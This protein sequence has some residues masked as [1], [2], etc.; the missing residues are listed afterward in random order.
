MNANLPSI[1]GIRQASLIVLCDFDGTIVDVDTC[2][3]ILDRFSEEDWKKLDVQYKKGEISLEKCLQSQF[4][5]LRMH[6]KNQIIHTVM[7][8]TRLRR[9][10]KKLVE[11][12]RTESIPL[13]II[14]AGLDFII[15]HFMKIN[16]WSN[17]IQIYSPRSE[18]T[19][20]GVSFTF[21]KLL[22]KTS[23]NFKDD[24]A[25]N[26]KE[27]N[28][29]VVY[30]GDGTSD[31]EAAKFADY[32]FAIE[33]SSLAQLLK[34]NHIPF[35]EVKT[36]LEVLEVVVKANERTQKETWNTF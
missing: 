17:D 29:T 32:P 19:S 30:I 16:R 20:K 6:D 22:Q 13:I 24:L 11:Y 5:K 35:K 25:R 31:F 10:F 23:T 36:F 21:P 14:S 33:N 3:L 28:K 7:Q 1:K 26:L 27:K 15:R 34:E 12:C 18:I 9:H 2:V 4:S 8:F